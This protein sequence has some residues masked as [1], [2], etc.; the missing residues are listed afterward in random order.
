MQ[1]S[2]VNTINKLSISNIVMLKLFV[3][4]AVKK[5]LLCVFIKDII[6]IFMIHKHH[7]NL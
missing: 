4:A 7:E 2:K 3:G 6:E 5:Q 1:N